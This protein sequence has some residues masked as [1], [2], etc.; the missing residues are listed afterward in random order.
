MSERDE[1]ARLDRQIDQAVDEFLSVPDNIVLDRVKEFTGTKESVALNFDRLIAPILNESRPRKEGDL[2]AQSAASLKPARWTSLAWLL[3]N[4]SER[5]FSSRPVRSAFALLVVVV[6]GTGLSV[7]LWRIA[8]AP[9]S[10]SLES[11]QTS[12]GV[13][14]MPDQQAVGS[15]AGGD[16]LYMAQLAKSLSFSRTAEVLDRV[17]ARYPALFKERS[18]VIRRA[19]GGEEPNAYIGCVAG[20]RSEQ[21]AEQLCSK[22]RAGG[23][24]CEVV[25]VTNDQ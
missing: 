8:T 6:A 21:D 20:I 3:S 12:R 19:N 11:N 5:V 1:H 17:N 9:Y 4:S 15:S 25:K 24:S 2:R 13:R 23:D 22:I 7:P 18:L 10:A 16:R 14:D